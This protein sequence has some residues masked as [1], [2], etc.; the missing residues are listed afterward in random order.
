MNIKNYKQT[1]IGF[2]PEDW[3]TVLLKDVS[4]KIGSGATPKGGKKSYIDN[5]KYSLIRSQ[6]IFD[7]KFDYN[8]LAYINKH[9]AKEL[10]NVEV[11]EGDVLLNITGASLGRVHIVPEEILPARV[12]Q[13]VSILRTNKKLDSYFLYCFLRQNKIKKYMMNFNAGATR[14]A[15]TKRMIENF[16]IPLPSIEEQKRIS[17]IFIKIDNKIKL[18]NKMNEKL[19]KIG[20]ALFKHW[21]ID[22]EFPNEDGKPYK[23][24]GGEMVDSELG[25]IP[26]G[27]KVEPIL[28]VS[29]LLSGGTPKT[30]EGKYWNGPINW[31]SVKDVSQ[32]I[33]DF[34]ISTE[35]K[36]TKIGLEKSNAKLLP[37]NTIIISSRGTVGNICIIGKEMAI[38]QSN[39]GLKAKIS[40]MDSYIYY[41]IKNIIETIKSQSYG[42]VFDTITTRTFKEIKVITPCHNM[43]DEI[44]GI[45]NF[46]SN[47]RLALK[48]FNNNLHHIKKILLPKLISGKIRVI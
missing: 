4:I 3:N 22:F 2:I 5:G 33:N 19:E 11:M 16:T 39:Y 8:G 31:V 45:L 48:Y 9:Q 40:I 18:N 38:N 1:E 37:Q 41:Y 14:E 21:F 26:Q 30:S 10:Q 34:I 7:D 23:S 17:K 15:L 24:S 29:D 43:S 44:F 27:W 25:M 35:K 28:N 32:N 36:I 42:S 13:H 12:N 47:K 20:Q 6:N 46:L